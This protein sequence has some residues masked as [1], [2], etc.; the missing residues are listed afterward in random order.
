MLWDAR[1]QTWI[2]GH[3][4]GG[5]TAEQDRGRARTDA[6]CHLPGKGDFY[7]APRSIFSQIGKF[8]GSYGYTAKGHQCQAACGRPMFCWGGLALYL[9]FPLFVS[10]GS[11]SIVS[12]ASYRRHHPHHRA[13]E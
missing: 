2:E 4:P 10:V 7:C 12:C 13:C 6:T 9:V 1:E 5:V 8:I 3:P 11:V